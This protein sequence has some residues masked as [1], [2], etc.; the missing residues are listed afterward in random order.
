[1][2]IIGS[3]LLVS[4]HYF[5]SENSMPL[6][7]GIIS[8]MVKIPLDFL[9]VGIFRYVLETEN[10]LLFQNYESLPPVVFP[11]LTLA[12]GITI[13]FLLSIGLSL[14]S[15]FKRIQFILS[16]VFIL[17]LLTLTGVNSLNIG[18]V[19]TNVAL[20]LLMAGFIL[21]AVI[22][23]TFYDHWN[24]FKRSMVIIPIALLTLP[25]LL[26]LSEVP[27]G[28]ILIS[29]NISM[30]G[31]AISAIFMLYI[32]HAVISSLFVFLAKL[33][34]G[35]GLRISWHIS[36]LFLIYL[37]F[38]IFIL[39]RITGNPVP[40]IPTPPILILFLIAGILGYFETQ[41]KIEQ[42][43]Q[44]YLLPIIG[45]ALYLIGFAVTVLVFWKA[46]FSVNRPMIDFLN[47]LFIYCQIAFGLLFYAYL[48][49]NFAGVMD[50]GS[51]VEKIIFQ[52]HYFAYYHMRIGASLAMLSLVVFADGI[53]A[54]HFSTASTNIAADYYYATDRP[55]EASILFE[56]SWE[57][58]RR[59]EKAINAVA[60]L[61][62]AQNQPTSA[63]NTLM[64]SFENNPSVNDILLLSSSLHKSGKSTEALFFLEKGLSLF[65]DNPFLLNNIAMLYSKNNR[66]EEAFNLLDQMESHPQVSIANKVGLQAKHLI[67]YDESLD[68]GQNPVAQINQL[69]FDNLKG[70]TASFTLNTAGIEDPGEVVD[71]AILRNQWSNKSE[72]TITK[73]FTLID[74]LLADNIQPAIEEELKETR[75]IRS[76]QDDYINE[77]LKY[78]NGMAFQF[79]KSAGF[80]HSMAA[81][82]LIG[83]I[84][85][86]KAAIELSQAE[87]KG[88][89]NFRPHHLPVL[90]FGNQKAKTL[91][92]ADR[93]DVSFPKWMNFDPEGDL[94]PNDTTVFFS[95]LSS[96]HIEIKRDFLSR[97]KEIKHPDFRAFFAYQILLRKGH[98]LDEE[99]IADLVLLIENS[100]KEVQDYE[101]LEEMV[102]ML[103]NGKVKENLPRNAGRLFDQNLSLGRNAYW[104]PLVFMALDQ[105]SDDMEKYNILLE[106]TDF[107]KDPL[108][109][110]NLVKYS[111]IIGMDSYASAAL[112]EMSEWLDPK[113]LE[114]L[115]L[116]NL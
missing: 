10:Y 26:F 107:S 3:I 16:M 92:I 96:L 72:R 58:Y 25:L 21:P 54:V 73:D 76:Y 42:I 33:N 105:S 63:I 88:F 93:Y 98:W 27:S 30:L 36:I 66:G 64:R 60:H 49:A 15:L 51:Q 62:I 91:E 116:Q 48:M 32:G 2:A 4:Y 104:T 35:V 100:S 102:E 18:G 11:K 12:C 5:F 101:F 17:F 38:L 94:L 22:I 8:E 24:I 86:E 80:Y 37:V 65:P 44:P 83:Q 19:H 114:E 111:R 78:I 87:E 75:V 77:T 115:Q 69:A 103:V 59:N 108:L 61:A 31:L 50:R 39:L 82:V 95:S 84:D 68:V 57:R 34:K 43:N 41:R 45:E 74:S 79:N 99:E 29:E 67:H 53:I 113:T 40:D 20:M 6:E 89:I 97:L 47:H 28:E 55:R 56:N 110:I 109:W 23:H 106:A 112:S 70:D 71:R 1:M 52:P 46:E 9:N 90:F 7:T 14:V 85:F 81:H 13:W